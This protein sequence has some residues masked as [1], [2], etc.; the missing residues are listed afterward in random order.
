M[1]GMTFMSVPRRGGR[2]ARAFRVDAGHGAFPPL[3]SDVE[4]QQA[5]EVQVHCHVLSAVEAGAVKG[6][7]LTEGTGRPVH[8]GVDARGEAVGSIGL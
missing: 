4:A 1:A 5:M 3:E 7:E 2:V 8:T 6:Q